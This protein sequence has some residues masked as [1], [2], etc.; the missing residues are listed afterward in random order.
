MVLIYTSLMTSDAEQLFMFLLAMCMHVLF[1]KMPEVFCPFFNQ[2][3]LMLSY[4]SCLYMEQ[5]KKFIW[6]FLLH[7]LEEP[8]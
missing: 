2:V 1:G 3:F 6:G 4:I 7:L 5:A 8:K